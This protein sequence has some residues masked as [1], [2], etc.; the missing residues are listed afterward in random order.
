MKHRQNHGRILLPEEAFEALQANTTETIKLEI[1]KGLLSEIGI[2]SAADEEIQGIQGKK[3]SG[4]TR[5]AKIALG[6]GEENEGI[7]L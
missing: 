6:L 4:I 3:A 5:D 2:L 7:L 1:D